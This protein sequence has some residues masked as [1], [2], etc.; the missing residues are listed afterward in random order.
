M[1]FR[2]VILKIKRNA[3]LNKKPARSLFLLDERWIPL[4]DTVL[5]V[6]REAIGHS[7][8]DALETF[9]AEEEFGDVRLQRGL[10]ELVFGYFFPIRSPVSDS[11]QVIE[12]RKR[13]FEWLHARGILFSRRDERKKLLMKFLSDELRQ[14]IQTVDEKELEL[15]FFADHDKF[16][17]V[18]DSGIPVTTELLRGKYN[19]EAFRALVRNSITVEVTLS[20]SPLGSMVRKLYF[21]AKKYGISVEFQQLDDSSTLIRLHGPVQ[22]VGRAVKYGNAMASFMWV[23]LRETLRTKNL[24]QELWVE[25]VVNDQRRWVHVDVTLLSE[26]VKQLTELQG[27]I[28]ASQDVG[29]DSSIEEAFYNQFRRCGAFSRLEY[30]APAIIHGNKVIIPDGIFKYHD[31]YLYLE[32]MG[33]WTDQYARRKVSQLNS[34]PPKMRD[35]FLVL[36]DDKLSVPDLKVSFFTF[37]GRKFPWKSIRAFLWERLEKEP[38]ELHLSRLLEK[39]EEVIKGVLDVLNTRGGVCEVPD[40]LTV[41][42]A[43][44]HVEGEHLIK[45]LLERSEHVHD[46]VGW[47]SH[48]RGLIVY[49]KSYLVSLRSELKEKVFSSSDL[50]SLD[51][52]N[53]FLRRKG[54]DDRLLPVLHELLQLR[55]RYV[56]LTEVAVQLVDS[57]S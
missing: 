19:W 4:L 2:D 33:Y 53:S 8:S 39:N 5:S 34:L 12:R 23:L 32:I 11:R 16:L 14:D 55:R 43:E 25:S 18:E 37:S 36:V 56:N 29:Y 50:A 45:A 57:A 44:T 26:S 47:Q 6:S 1:K 27:E 54:I 20:S 30:D 28:I 35:R 40:L 22:L 31:E 46:V 49:L 17:H 42:K 52:V 41:V 51:D 15:L 9:P 3:P 10:F 7:L 21:I 24:L 38:F 48:S 13:L